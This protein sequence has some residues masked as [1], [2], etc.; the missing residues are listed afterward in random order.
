MESEDHLLDMKHAPVSL[1]KVL[2]PGTRSTS[3]PKPFSFPQREKK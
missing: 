2:I 1:P 3:F